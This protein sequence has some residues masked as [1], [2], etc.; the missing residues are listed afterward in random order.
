MDFLALTVIDSLEFL[1]GTDVAIPSSFSI[2]SSNSKVSMA[3]R[4]ILLIKVKIGICL[5]TQ[6]LNN[7]LVCASTPLD[8]SITITAESAA[9]RVR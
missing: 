8:P 4:S 9:I 6:T 3:S 7:F 2:S 1:T 5:M